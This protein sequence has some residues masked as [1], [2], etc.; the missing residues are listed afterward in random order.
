MDKAVRRTINLPDPSCFPHYETEMDLTK[1]KKALKPFVQDAQLYLHTC[2]SSAPP[3]HNHKGLCIGMSLAVLADYMKRG[4][5]DEVA[6]HLKP[7]ADLRMVKLTTLYSQ[8][9]E[10]SKHTPPTLGKAVIAYTLDHHPVL[11]LYTPLQTSSSS[12]PFQDRVS[13][14]AEMKN[15][16]S[17]RDAARLDHFVQTFRPPHR[18]FHKQ[19]QTLHNRSISMRYRD[20]R[21]LTWIVNAFKKSLGRVSFRKT[22]LQ[23]FQNNWGRSPSCAEYSSILTVDKL[24]EQ[25][26]PEPLQQNTY[27]RREGSIAEASFLALC[28]YVGI[29]TTPTMVQCLP[30]KALE[31]MSQK[32]RGYWIDTG[33]HCFTLVHDSEGLHLFDPNV[34]LM[35]NITNKELVAFLKKEKEKMQEER[36][37]APSDEIFSTHI[38]LWTFPLPNK[39]AGIAGQSQM[40]LHR[41]F[42]GIFT[43]PEIGSSKY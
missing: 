6:R 39:N 5:I 14:T 32:G 7:G 1:L 38:D 9:Y 16:R 30:S 4:S 3:I 37:H 21:R 31:I 27:I 42:C 29:S 13:T 43:I 10:W 35:K 28:R 22:A 33:S 34:G 12:T 23:H 2:S 24:F 11:S 15:Q 8:M 36:C 18:S 41:N 25:Q 19:V 20:G 40:V 17:H 26:F